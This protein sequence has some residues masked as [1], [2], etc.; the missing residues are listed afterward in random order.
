MMNDHDN[1][2]KV[3][4]RC[5][6]VTPTTEE[7]TTVACRSRVGGLAVRPQGHRRR[8]GLAGS[9]VAAGPHRPAGSAATR[10]GSMHGRG[11]RIRARRTPRRPEHAPPPG[12][13]QPARRA[14][15]GPPPHHPSDL[16]SHAPDPL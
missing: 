15:I 8:E 4:T 12:Q 13:H 14:Q 5:L 1:H 11:G 9:D 3:T 2:T 6:P 10:A 16:R 7:S